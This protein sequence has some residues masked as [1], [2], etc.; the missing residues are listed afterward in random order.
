[1]FCVSNKVMHLQ[2]KTRFRFFPS[3]TILKVLILSIMI[4]ASMEHLRLSASE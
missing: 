2:F 1:M 3:K 4:S